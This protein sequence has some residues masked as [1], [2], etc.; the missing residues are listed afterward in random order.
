MSASADADLYAGWAR[1][2]AADDPAALA[3]LFDATHDALVRYAAALL[4]DDAAARDAVQEAFVRVW[5]RRATLDP[6]R[7][8][9]ALL[10]QTVRHLA[11]NVTRD[12]RTRA[13]LLEG[14]PDAAAPWRP[15]APDDWAVA[16]DL[17][18]RLRRW[19]GALPARQR[20]ALALSRFD[21]LSHDEIAEVMGCAPRTVNNHLVRALATLRD[22]LSGEPAAE[23]LADMTADRLAHSRPA[24]SLV[25]PTPPAA[26]P[27]PAPAS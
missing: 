19:I 12:A 20:E 8:L 18:R 26:T 23:P 22:R 24:P 2:L 27:A 15:P 10:Y 6:A 14:A 9:R 5:E 17:G 1:R 21:G 3:E 11:F 7:P 16:R 13:R 4:R 25:A